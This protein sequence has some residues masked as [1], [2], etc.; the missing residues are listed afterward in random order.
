MMER[1]INKSKAKLEK[2]F[3]NHRFQEFSPLKL[4]NEKDYEEYFLSHPYLRYILDYF[5]NIKGKSILDLGCGNGWVSIYFARSKAN[6]YCCDISE[7]AIE[8]TQEMARVNNIKLKADVMSSEELKYEDG[9]F[10]FIFGNA[11]LHHTELPQARDEI[12]RVLK[13]GGK[14]AF[15]EP[16]VY[17]TLL[18]L[19]RRISKHVHSPEE[20]PLTYEDIYTFGK[21]FSEL[22]FKEFQILVLPAIFRRKLKSHLEKLDDKILTTYPFL[23]KYCQMVVIRCIK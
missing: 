8:I 22:S 1:K 12:Y 2:I 21:P 11:I 19:Y 6:V 3:W 18:Q 10:D 9:K 20:N 13:K 17:N 7:K 4:N 23:K 5:G 15:I 16:M 14:A